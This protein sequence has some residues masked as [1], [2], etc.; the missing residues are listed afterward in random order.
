MY[1][2]PIKNIYPVL[3]LNLRFSLCIPLLTA[4]SCSSQK[5][6]YNLPIQ[7]ESLEPCA[8]L[9][10]RQIQDGNA[11]ARHPR[12]LPSILC[13]NVPKT[14]SSRSRPL[15]CPS[16]GSYTLVSQALNGS[17]S[18]NKY[19]PRP[20]VEPQILALYPAP[21]NSQ[22]FLPK[23]GIQ[24]AQIVWVAR[25]VRTPVP[26]SNLGR[27]CSGEASTRPPV[28]FMEFTV[29]VLSWVTNRMCPL[30]KIRIYTLPVSNPLVPHTVHSVRLLCPSWNTRS[31]PPHFSQASILPNNLLN[32]DPTS[33]TPSRSSPSDG[34]Y[35]PVS[36]A[37]NIDAPI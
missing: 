36:Q 34:S 6:G 13:L 1:V 16:D 17:H 4:S 10:R 15:R 12:D 20:S 5:W 21:N 35:S 9:S 31:L 26:P 32:M 11:P 2:T 29:E 8:L 19:L 28:K 3:R 22:M 7:P 23:V 25:T 37:L 24:P 18:L 33:F 30:N 27:R 14:N